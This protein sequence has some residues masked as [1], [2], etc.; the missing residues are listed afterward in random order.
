MA[1]PS[2]RDQPAALQLRKFALARSRARARIPNQLRGIEAALG[3]A[4]QHTEDAL[5]CLGEQRIRQAFSARSTRARWTQ[6]G[7]NHARS[8]YTRQP[9]ARSCRTPRWPHRRGCQRVE[10]LRLCRGGSHRIPDGHPTSAPWF[11]NSLCGGSPA[12]TPA[13]PDWKNRATDDEL[14]PEDLSLSV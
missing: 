10:L 3:L 6:Y 7:H 13:R 5:L 14:K 11:A 8:G 4:E 2:R 1:N 9:A 12:Q